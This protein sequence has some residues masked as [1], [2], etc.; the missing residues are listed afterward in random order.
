[1]RRKCEIC[2]SLETW[3]APA[4]ADQ[5]PASDRQT[6]RTRRLL[7]QDRVVAVCDAHA[8]VIAEAGCTTLEQLCELFPEAA[9][10]RSLL[11][12]RAALDRRVF[13]PRP[14]GRRHAGGRRAT[15]AP[16]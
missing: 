7:L 1:M 3:G 6:A 8:Q 13:P 9:G 11:P 16:D 10:Y 14:E 12:R 5:R 2:A 15:D 4:D